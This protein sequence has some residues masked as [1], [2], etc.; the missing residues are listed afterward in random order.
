MSELPGFT[1]PVVW[2]LQ[3]REGRLVAGEREFKGRDFFELRLWAGQHGDTATSKGVTM[4][5]DAV[6][7]LAR[8]LTAY[9]EEK[10]LGVPE[11]GSES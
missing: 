9:A 5:I 10:A 4:P 2:E 1:A 7:D 8:A 3:K 6:A 11:T